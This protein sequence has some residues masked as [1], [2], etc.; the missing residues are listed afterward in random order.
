MP[1]IAISDTSFDTDVLQAEKPVLVDFW[2]EWCGPCKVIGPSL[3]EIA[4]ELADQV[5]ITKANLDDAPDAATRYGI[6]T[7]PNLVLFKGGQE[8]ARFSRAAP[9]SQLKAWLEG[10]L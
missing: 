10:N 5:T 8:V 4:D 3:E 7:I 6:R 9:K 1:T 2:A